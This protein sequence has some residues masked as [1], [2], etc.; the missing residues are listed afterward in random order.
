[1][2]W[3]E[4]TWLLCEKIED[5]DAS[6]WAASRTKPR[7]EL[8]GPGEAAEGT[9]DL[10]ARLGQA[11]ATTP[12]GAGA[13]E[14]EHTAD[15]RTLWVDYDDQGERYKEW[16]RVAQES[17]AQ[18]FSDFQSD[19]PPKQVHL[20]K[21]MLRHGGDPRMWLQ[22][23]QREKKLEATDKVVHEMKVLTDSLFYARS[24]EQ[25]NVGARVAMEV[26]CRRIQLLVDAYANPLRPNWDMAK[27]FNGQA[28]PDD[29]ISPSFRSWATKRSR[30]EAEIASARAKVRELRGAPVASGSGTDARDWRASGEAEAGG[31]GRGDSGGRQRH[32]RRRR[33]GKWPSPRPSVGAWWREAPAVQRRSVSVPAPSARASGP[34]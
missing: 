1:M 24:Y 4:G 11:G 16:R 2:L 13:E 15:V 5:S 18:H 7:V 30:D 25:I 32:E 12:R 22:L 19:G 34:R 6:G 21:H 20:C 23:W 31:A 3:F 9:S 17:H 33:R 8:P 14:D 28:S 27:V 26:I 29:G 10:R